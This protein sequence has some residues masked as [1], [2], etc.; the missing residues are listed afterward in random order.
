VPKCKRV[1]REHTEDWQTIQQYTLWP[2]QTAYELLLASAI[3][4][5]QDTA[6]YLRVLTKALR[7]YGAPEA[8]V[9]DARSMQR[10]NLLPYISEKVMGLSLEITDRA[11]CSVGGVWRWF[12]CV[13]GNACTII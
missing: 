6:A 7:N 5:K 13:L 11:L 8:I 4:E 2:E 9:T 10:A 3:S 1:Q 12:F